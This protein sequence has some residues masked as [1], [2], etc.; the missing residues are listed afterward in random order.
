[1]AQKN[2]RYEILSA[3]VRWG[4]SVSTTTFLREAKYKIAPVR[5]KHMRTELEPSWTG[6]KLPFIK[7][8]S[9]VAFWLDQGKAP[10][11]STGPYFQKAPQVS[12]C[13]G[14]SRDAPRPLYADAE[15]KLRQDGVFTVEKDGK[16]TEQAIK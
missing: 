7:Q 5:R 16:F 3:R 2:T 8:L 1:M 12:T 13:W 6:P 4:E 10:A 11:S 14:S 15:F 9:T